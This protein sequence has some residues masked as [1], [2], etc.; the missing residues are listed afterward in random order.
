MGR[1]SLKQERQF[2]EL[3]RANL[4][5]G[6]IATTMELP[7]ARVQRAAK[8]M[9]FDIPPIAPKRSARMNAKQK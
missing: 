9:G 1:W 4:N 5:V 6:Q 7:P 8:R 2:I 3:A